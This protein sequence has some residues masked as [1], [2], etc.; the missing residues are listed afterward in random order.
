MAAS[1]K[2]LSVR[3]NFGGG[4]A[5]DVGPA[6]DGGL[7]QNMVVLIPFLLDAKNVIYERDG[8]PRKK[9][10]T[11]KLNSSAL[12]AG[13]SVRGLVDFWRMGTAGTPTQKR[14]VHVG[15]KIKADAADGVFG[16]IKTGVSASSI[17][18]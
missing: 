11:T 12:E 2:T 10:G 1:P 9:W 18:N 17:P 5:T 6:F 15:T 8:G 7:D 3:M 16:D 14:I 4:W 13:L